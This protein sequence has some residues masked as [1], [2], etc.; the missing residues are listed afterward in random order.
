MSRYIRWRVILFLGL[1]IA[2]AAGAPV[3][4]E[5]AEP[6]ADND[7]EPVRV[8]ECPEPILPE[9]CELL[10]DLDQESAE[11]AEI[12]VTALLA[13]PVPAPSN[14]QDDDSI[15]N[16]IEVETFSEFTETRIRTGEFTRF[17]ALRYAEGRVN[18]WELVGD[19]NVTR[20]LRFDRTFEVGQGADL[21][22]YLS[23]SAN[24]TSGDMLFEGD[25]AYD[26]GLLKGNVGGQNYTLPTDLD[27]T[28]FASVVIYSTTL[29]MIFS[30]APL[31]QPIQ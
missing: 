3:W 16:G 27:I 11:K 14:E 7:S 25:L 17:D 2:I 13:D 23:V 8:F 28:Q 20:V 4:L 24:P 12:F 5:Y 15:R 19:G 1:L 9:Q 29:E 6:L 22:V 31:Q 18:L 26:A 30:V 21:H 10:S